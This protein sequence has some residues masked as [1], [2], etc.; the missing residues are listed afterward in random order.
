MCGIEL[1]IISKL[2]LMLF[3]EKLN[4]HEIVRHICIRLCGTEATGRQVILEH[5]N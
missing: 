1:N 4:V 5:M 2:N 3:R